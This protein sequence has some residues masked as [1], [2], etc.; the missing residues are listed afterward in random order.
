MLVSRL[1]LVG[2]V[3]LLNLFFLVLPLMITVETSFQNGLVSYKK[4]LTSPL[5]PHVVETTV[6]ISIVTTLLTIALAYVLALALWRSTGTWRALAFA[7]VL[8]P[9]WTGILVKNFAWAVLLQHNG[10]INN[11]LVLIGFH[12]LILLHNRFA[13]TVGMIHYLLPYAVF[14]I[15]AA[16][17]SIDRNLEL[18]AASLGAGRR[19]I[20][21][22][23]IFP[24]SLPG[25]YAATLLVFVISLGFYVT[26]AVL[27][28]PREMMI[29][30]LVDFFAHSLVDFQ[31]ASALSVVM[32]LAVSALVVGY[33]ILVREAQYERR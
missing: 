13:V 32:A 19:Q 16:L 20:A 14:P 24:L 9:F 29:A 7:L 6:L 23:I 18:S 10:I 25:V 8:L 3:L 28:S 15:Y 2:P 30:N 12:P 21:L 27:G 1:A 5:F 26:P 17:I 22:E 33:Q 4:V 31:A 11:T